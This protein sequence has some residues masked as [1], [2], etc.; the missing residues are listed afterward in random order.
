MYD[1]LID[2]MPFFRSKKLPYPKVELNGQ[3]YYVV[4]PSVAR[5]LDDIDVCVEGVIKDKPRVEY[6]SAGWPWSFERVIEENHGHRTV[7]KLNDDL[8]VVIKGI[9]LVRAGEKVKIYGKAKR[10]VLNAKVVIGEL[11]EYYS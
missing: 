10:G 5:D 4:T 3:E 9:V 6:Y 7:F 8:L 11:A 1:I 2:L